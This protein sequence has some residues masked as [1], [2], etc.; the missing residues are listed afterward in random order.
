VYD[1]FY[2]KLEKQ[3]K[4]TQKIITQLESLD[5]KISSAVAITK[6]QNKKQI[7][8]ELLSLN[9]S[10]INLLTVEKMKQ[11]I[12]NQNINSHPFL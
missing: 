4:N 12:Q 5:K 10:K 1:R 3:I 2:I 6:N 7:L 8:N 11:N 9:T